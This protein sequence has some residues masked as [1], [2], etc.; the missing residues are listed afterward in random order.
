LAGRC[1]SVLLLP[2]GEVSSP[3]SGELLPPGEVILLLR[4]LEPGQCIHARA[5]IRLR[6]LGASG[7]DSLQLCGG[8]FELGAA[9]KKEGGG[10]ADEGSAGVP[11]FARLRSAS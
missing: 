9:G 8:G 7:F 5:P 4:D 11:R 1:G 10:E 6:A 3:N 2:R